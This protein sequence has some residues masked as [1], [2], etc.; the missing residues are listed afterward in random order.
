MR[1]KKVRALISPYLDEMTDSRETILVEAHLAECPGCL[2]YANKMRG[3]RQAMLQTACP[4]PPPGLLGDIRR[5]LYEESFRE[6]TRPGVGRRLRVLAGKAW[7]SRFKG[8]AIRFYRRIKKPL[9]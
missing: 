7:G 8:E 3:M 9:G 2:Q 5:H 4:L 1:C 6:Q